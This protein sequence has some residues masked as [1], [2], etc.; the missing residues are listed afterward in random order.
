MG[1]REFDAAT[2]EKLRGIAS[3]NP[4]VKAIILAGCYD[5]NDLGFALQIGA[6]GLLRQ[7]TP[8][9]QLI[10]SLELI[11]HGQM[12]FDRRFDQKAVPHQI[13]E[14]GVMSEASARLPDTSRMRLL[15]AASPAC[16]ELRSE[17]VPC[18]KQ[19]AVP[20]LSRRE[21]LVLQHLIDGASNKVIAFKLVMT[22]STVKVHMKS[23]LR[24]LRMQNRTQAAMWAK[25]HLPQRQCLAG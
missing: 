2:K 16:E 7:D 15:E 11:L 6:C 5:A 12:V 1:V 14:W 10:K 17:S 19:G 8:G 20:A 18:D 13:D 4:A 9:Q 24:K 23:I 21:A 3:L 25:G 22:E